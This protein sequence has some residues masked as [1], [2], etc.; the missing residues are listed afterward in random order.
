MSDCYGK[1]DCDYRFALKSSRAA[2]RGSG[3]FLQHL[4]SGTIVSFPQSGWIRS[5]GPGGRKPMSDGDQWSSSVKKEISESHVIV[6]YKS[7]K[8][9]KCLKNGKKSQVKVMS[10]NAWLD[11]DLTFFTV[12]LT[13]TWLC[14]LAPN[15][16]VTL[17]NF[18]F[19]R[20]DK[21]R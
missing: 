12:F 4:N 8:S 2:L 13:F 11:F 9:G 17:G 15:Y 14:W 3:I 19:Y 5:T 16:H 21:I 10:E 6:K 18:L 20:V 1:L 7:T